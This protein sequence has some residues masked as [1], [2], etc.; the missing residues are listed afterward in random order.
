MH[1][2]CQNR[3]IGALLRR[4][5]GGLGRGEGGPFKERSSQYQ[6]V[7]AKREKLL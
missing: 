7:H 2:V 1:V 4:G 5:G 3:E 6:L